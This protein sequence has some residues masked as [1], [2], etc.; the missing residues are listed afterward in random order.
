MTGLTYAQAAQAVA[1]AA[2]SRLGNVTPLT[3]EEVAEAFDVLGII[4]AAF[5]PLGAGLY[6]QTVTDAELAHLL[7]EHPRRRETVTTDH[8]CPPWCSRAA[9]PHGHPWTCQ[10]DGT[11]ERIHLNKWTTG[12]SAAVW[13]EH[14]E[15]IPAPGCGPV[16]T[17][18]AISIEGEP[19]DLGITALGADHARA[20]A[21]ALLAAADAHNHT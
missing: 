1:D 12:P 20:I 2:R 11:L 6:V 4:A 19:G 10:D 7:P 5:R 14:A 21:A 16:T 18:S 8:P 3:L 13:I 15:T 17:D 9:S